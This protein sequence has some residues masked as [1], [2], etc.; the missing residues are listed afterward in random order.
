MFLLK[1]LRLGNV[2]KSDWQLTDGNTGVFT[3]AREMA[4][5]ASFSQNFIE[6]FKI[7]K[8]N[9]NQICEFCKLLIYNNNN[10]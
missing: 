1:F 7:N 5:K 10:K 9:S 8:I 3:T 2:A 4:T 6:V